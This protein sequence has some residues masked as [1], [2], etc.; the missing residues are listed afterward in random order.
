MAKKELNYLQKSWMKVG[1]D[2]C[3]T[4][5]DPVTGIDGPGVYQLYG[6]TNDKWQ[7]SISLSESGLMSIY[8]DGPF[9]IHAGAKSQGNINIQISTTS[10]DI[11]ITANKNGAVRIRSTGDMT[12]DCDGNMT[13]NSGRDLDINVAGAL[14]IGALSADI[15]G[16]TGNLLPEGESFTEKCFAKSKVGASAV[17]GFKVTSLLS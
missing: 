10:G 4:V 3:I 2:F 16:Q 13:I 17:R 11:T 1:Q 9:E 6:V 15:K 14:R 8:N 12:L 7:S 5:K